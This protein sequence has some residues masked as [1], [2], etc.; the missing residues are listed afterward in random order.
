M[1]WIEDKNF[2][3]GPYHPV[4]WYRLVGKGKPFTRPWGT[5]KTSGRMP[6]SSGSW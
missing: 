4:A 6:I 3:M 1:L 5:A 2:G